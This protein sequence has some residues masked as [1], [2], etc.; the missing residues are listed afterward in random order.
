MVS[1]D[2]P[3][4]GYGFRSR[5]AVLHE[6]Y[7]SRFWEGPLWEASLY[8]PFRSSLLSTVPFCL[9]EK[10]RGT[11]VR[12]AVHSIKIQEASR[13]HIPLCNYLTANSLFFLRATKTFHIPTNRPVFRGTVPLFNAMSR[14]PALP[15]IC[16]AFYGTQSDRH[17][18]IYSYNKLVS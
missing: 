5:T 7:E 6:S 15:H 14:C 11:A 16:P 3:S 17:R 8:I 2:C 12:P 9:K 10:N 18:V 13:S 1:T 4:L